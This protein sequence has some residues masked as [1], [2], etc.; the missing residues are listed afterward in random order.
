MQALTRLRKIAYEASRHA[1][2]GF[3]WLV[4]AD[5]DP[6]GTEYDEQLN[7][8]KQMEGSGTISK[9]DKQR[10]FVWRTRCANVNVDVRDQLHGKAVRE[11]LERA[12]MVFSDFRSSHEGFAVI[13][14]EFDEL[15]AAVYANDAD[16]AFY[17]AM[18]VAAMALRFMSDLNGGNFTLRLDRGQ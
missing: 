4:L 14:E 3:A 1:L 9:Q 2:A 13:E 11:E 7:R 5:D 8:E 16:Q 12:R 15:R 10:A 18:Q 6:Y 17:E